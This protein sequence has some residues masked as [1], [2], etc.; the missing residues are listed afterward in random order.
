M[1][2]KF[3][4]IEGTDGAGKTTQ[5]NLLMEYLK[6]EGFDVVLTREPGGTYIGEKIREL[7]LD[8]ENSS[9]SY[10]TEALLYAA[11]RAQHVNEKILP[12]LNDGKIVV[13]DRFV[14]SSIAYQGFARELGFKTIESINNYAVNSLAPDITFYL[15]ISPEI[16]IARKRDSKVLDRIEV[17]K[18]EFHNSVYKGF[19]E[20][21]NCYTDRIKKINADRSIEDISND[22]IEEVKKI[23]F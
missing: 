2:G 21:C 23:I 4:T 12:A 15:D 9:M 7:L 10:M 19:Q 5:I 20:L 14:D 1:T 13:C 11:A 18:M 8:T 17:E 3:I 22:I 16:G 6:H